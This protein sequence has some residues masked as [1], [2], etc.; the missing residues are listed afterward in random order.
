MVE[1]KASVYSG[2][3][4]KQPVQLGPGGGTLSEAAL[5]PLTSRLPLSSGSLPNNLRGSICVPTTLFLT[6][7]PSGH[8]F[9]QEKPSPP[10]SSLCCFLA[11][12]GLLTGE[13]E[14]SPVPIP[15]SLLL[16]PGCGV[17]PGPPFHPP[18]QPSP[19]AIAQAA[20]GHWKSICRVTKGRS[21]AGNTQEAPEWW[22]VSH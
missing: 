18:Q 6:C 10:P 12:S 4:K 16:Q 5:R 20:G 3:R 2:E 13:K 7:S 1:A 17:S 21:L 11:W 19:G 22:P 14:Q 15:P 9:L 8:Y